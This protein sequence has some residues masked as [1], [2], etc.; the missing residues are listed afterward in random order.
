MTGILTNARAA[1]YGDSPVMPRRPALLNNW[2]PSLAQWE[3][4][5]EL[6]SE[7][8][9]QPGDKFSALQLLGALNPSVIAPDVRTRLAEIAVT[10]PTGPP[11]DWDLPG[12]GN[13]GA[14]ALRLA[15][16]LGVLQPAA[17]ATALG[18][19][20]AST[21]EQRIGAVWLASELGRP[22]DL[23]ILL[24]LAHD[25][26][27]D[28]RTTVRQTRPRPWYHRCPGT[29]AG[30]RR[31][32]RQRSP[33]RTR[34]QH[35]EEGVQDGGVVVVV[36]ALVRGRGAFDDALFDFVADDRMDADAQGQARARTDLPDPGGPLT[37]VITGFCAELGMRHCGRSLVI[38]VGVLG[39]GLMSRRR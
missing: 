21:D 30:A 20:L 12:Q 29:G 14:A 32:A 8:L 31:V 7:P 4:L 39:A 37:T 17:A 26:E 9:V 18:Q 10:I 13:A 27:A 34:C 19:L 1:G 28:V 11:R 22:E 38:D 23:G 5:L 15:A 6:L 2:H 24:T 36:V 3:P 16:H 25:A 33:G 35:V